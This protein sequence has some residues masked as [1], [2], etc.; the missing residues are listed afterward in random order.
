MTTIQI[1]VKDGKVVCGAKGGHLRVPHGTEITWTSKDKDQKFEL[2]FFRLDLEVAGSAHDHWPFEKPPAP[3]PG[4]Q[5]TFTGTLKAVPTTAGR[6][7]AYKYNVRV[8][9]LL[10]DPIIIVDR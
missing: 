2:E 4:A 8:A 10:L 1:D 3:V 6:A 7:P 5:H 9:E